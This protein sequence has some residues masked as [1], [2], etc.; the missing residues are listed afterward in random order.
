MQARCRGHASPRVFLSACDDEAE[1]D[2]DAASVLH[3]LVDPAEAF[4]QRSRGFLLQ[5]LGAVEQAEV[6]LPA[7]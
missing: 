5:S 3:E 6:R 2:T 4:A 7:S 1:P